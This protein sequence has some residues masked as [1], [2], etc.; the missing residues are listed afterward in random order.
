MDGED[1]SDVVERVDRGGA[2]DATHLA[3]G[4]VLR[5]LQRAN[6]AF[7]GNPRKPQGCTVGERRQDDGVENTP[8]VGIRDPSDGVTQYTEGEDCRSG[9]CGE[10]GDMV[11]PGELVVEEDAQVPHYVLAYI[12]SRDLGLPWP[13]PLLLPSAF[14]MHYLSHVPL[15]IGIIHL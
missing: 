7:L 2:K 3:Q 14:P 15:H 13:R 5:N 6:K 10:G 4:I 12:Y 9:A 8:P 11:F 1:V